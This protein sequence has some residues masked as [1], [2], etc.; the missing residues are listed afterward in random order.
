VRRKRVRDFVA[1][2]GDGKIRGKVEGH[3]NCEKILPAMSLA[4]RL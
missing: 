3:G 4:K 1:V 2:R